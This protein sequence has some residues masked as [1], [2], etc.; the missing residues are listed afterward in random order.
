MSAVGHLRSRT[1]LIALAV[2]FLA[3]IPLKDTNIG[4]TQ[5]AYDHVRKLFE[6]GELAD[7]QREAEKGYEEF[8]VSQPEW[9]EKFELL[10]AESLEWSGRYEDALSLLA[11]YRPSSNHPED[12][13]HKLVIEAIALTHQQQ[14]D[15][16]NQRLLQA[17]SHCNTNACSIYGDVLQ[18]RGGLA[19]KQGKLDAAR[20]FYLESFSFAQARQDRF[21][22]ARAS[23]NLGWIALQVNHYDEAADW[24]RSAYQ[25]ASN[26]GAGDL[27]QAAS[28]NL[29]W[30]DYQLGDDETALGI[31]LNAEKNAAKLGDTHDELRW[32]S[33]AGYIYRDTG[34]LER[35]AQSYRQSLYLAKQIDSKESIV[36]ALEDLAEVSIDLGKLDEAGTYLDQAIPKEKAGGN[37]LSSNIMLTRGRLAVAR[38][39]TTQAVALFRAIQNDRADSTMVR[40]DAGDRLAELYEHEGKTQEAEREYRATLIA[41][42][43]ARSQLTND[44]SRLPFAANSTFIY[45]DYIHL[46]VKQGR[47]EEALAAADQSRARTLAQG[48]GVEERGALFH[49][50]ALDPRAISRKAGATLLFY[51]LGETESYLWAV[52]PE[53]I[54]LVKLPRRAE[55]AAR[56][57]RYRE[58]LLDMDDPLQDRD[59]DGQALYRMLVAPVAKLLRRNAPVMILAD[60]ALS[61]LNFETLLVPGPGP[62]AG[63]ASGPVAPLHYLIDDATLLSAPSLAMLAAAE[64]E[65][66]G[67]RGLLL[68][69]NPVTPSPDY[70][71]LPLFGAEMTRVASHFAARNE[72]VFAGPQATPDA[73]LNGD[74]ARYAYIHFVAHATASQTDPLDS[75]IILSREKTDEDSFKL[76][77]REIM[78]HP[79]DA[80]LVTISA[81]YGSGTRS[82]AGE[83]LVGLSWAFLRAGAHS[84]V[85]ALWEVSDESTPRLMNAL[86]QGMEDGQAPAAA[87]RNAKLSLLHSQSR[88]RAPFY[89]APFQLYTR[90]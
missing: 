16:A 88:F 59:E 4:S 48:L 15:M 51:W 47:S 81:C 78:K 33:N 69:G 56:A 7:S 49:P 55:I 25:A 5:S 46:L 85:G 80:R 26:L 1:R 44:T 32:M 70:P 57:E 53:R 62:E 13:A 31:F 21:L 71:S 67:R 54:T 61:K 68:L 89:W 24:S 90:Q 14:P 43:T 72:T 29:G 38:H 52:T 73:Y 41:F 20:K 6:H 18:A 30:A 3:L 35:A 36:I 22:E 37:L 83:G 63:P 74:P 82:Y 77:A 58:T 86:Y 23:L 39:Q 28:G 34:D 42:E 40:L 60:G 11:G 65:R 50:A 17:E 64:P 75:A 8:K 84:V 9:A 10:E 76:Y 27:E 87:L 19:A 79:I 2:I 66:P 45:D 12:T